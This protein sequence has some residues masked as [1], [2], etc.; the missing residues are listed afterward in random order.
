MS[1]PT[2]RWTGKSRLDAPA[3]P[4][5]LSG[6]RTHLSIVQDAGL[7]DLFD[8]LDAVGEILTAISRPDAQRRQW[9]GHGSKAHQF[10]KIAPEAGTACR[11]ARSASS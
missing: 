5:A 1:R 11:L 7:I 6:R 10:P 8:T 2:S 4:E 3:W 9:E